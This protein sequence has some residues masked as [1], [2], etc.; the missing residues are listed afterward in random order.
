MS[1][2][3]PLSAAFQPERAM[4][5]LTLTQPWASAVAFGYKH[6]ETRSWQTSY[7]GRL[8]IHA[9]KGFP[10]WAKE[11]A[12]QERA[13]GRYPGEGIPLGAIV[14]VATLV[15][16]RRA[17]EVAYEIGGLE[18]LYGDYS[19][20]RFAWVLEDIDPLTEPVYCTGAQGLWDVHPD[21]EAAVLAAGGGDWPGR[22][23]RVAACEKCW[24]DAFVRARTTGRPQVDCYY[25][26]LKERAQTPCTPEQQK[27]EE[28][29][30]D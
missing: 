28:A 27:G 29:Q 20:G 30:G 24:T 21:I 7:R 16:I 17:E 12:Q 9:A 19:F 1:E 25:E 6:I 23:L 3:T 2:P 5:A 22:R 8:A 11:F 13:V 15:R 14:A 10:G 18:R 4:K 26:L